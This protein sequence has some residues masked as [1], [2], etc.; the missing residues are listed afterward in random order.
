MCFGQSTGCIEL[1]I[2]YQGIGFKIQETIP[3]SSAPSTQGDGYSASVDK[4][5][6]GK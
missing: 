2:L 4:A 3:L 5:S 1:P 6:M